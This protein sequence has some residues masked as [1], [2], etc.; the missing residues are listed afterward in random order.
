MTFDKFA[1]DP[2]GCP[3]PADQ[4]P[5]QTGI[6]CMWFQKTHSVLTIDQNQKHEYLAQGQN[7]SRILMNMLKL[8]STASNATISSHCQ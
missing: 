8:L 2:L 1:S 3:L 6:F 7:M 5:N 4:N